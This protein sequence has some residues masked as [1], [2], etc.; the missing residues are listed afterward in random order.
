MNNYVS[1]VLLGEFLFQILCKK[2]LSRI[3]H[4]QSRSKYL[5]VTAIIQP[6]HNITRRNAS[7]N[8]PRHA[9]TAK[10]VD[11]YNNPKICNNR[12]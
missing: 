5:C 4:D 1:R 12:F 7:T 2:N 3:E 9:H 8:T 11:Q 6:S 10:H